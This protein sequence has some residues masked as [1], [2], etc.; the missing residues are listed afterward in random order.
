MYRYSDVYLG[1]SSLTKEFCV[2]ND[3]LNAGG[4]NTNFVKFPKNLHAK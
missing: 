1:D 4:W 2:M 3:V